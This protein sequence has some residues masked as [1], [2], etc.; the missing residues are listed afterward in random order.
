MNAQTWHPGGEGLPSGWWG[1]APGPLAAR[2]R[3]SGSAIT[4]LRGASDMMVPRLRMWGCAHTQTGRIRGHVHD[5]A[6][7]TQSIQGQHAYCHVAIDNYLSIQAQELTEA[8]GG[9]VNCR[10]CPVVARPHS[11]VVLDAPVK[12]KEAL[13]AAGTR[14]CG[15]CVSAVRAAV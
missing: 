12:G 8:R 4:S 5:R 7:S 13:C 9:I 11:V 10:C 14:V 1:G 3:N 2:H 15:P 6:T